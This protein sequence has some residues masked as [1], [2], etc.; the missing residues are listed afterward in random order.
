MLKVLPT[1]TLFIIIICIFGCF[2]S[3]FLFGII[4]LSKSIDSFFECYNVW[5]NVHVNFFIIIMLLLIEVLAGNFKRINIFYTRRD[6]PR[7]ED[8][9]LSETSTLCKYCTNIF[10]FFM[11]GAILWCFSVRYNLNH[12]K[13]CQNIYQQKYHSLYVYSIITFYVNIIIIVIYFLCYCFSDN[14][15]NKKKYNEIL[16]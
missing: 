5:L 10:R 15:N 9:L 2:L 1:C 7:D 12:D 8:E 4:I 11:F 16:L 3:Y 13:E 6:R 14:N